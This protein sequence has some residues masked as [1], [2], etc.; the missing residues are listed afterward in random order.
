[1]HYFWMGEPWSL[2]FIVHVWSYLSWTEL[3]SALL[4]NCPVYWSWRLGIFSKVRGRHWSFSYCF[5]ARWIRGRFGTSSQRLLRGHSKFIVLLPQSVRNTIVLAHTRWTPTKHRSKIQSA[6]M[7]HVW[8]M[9][10][11]ICMMREL[12]RL[13]CVPA[14]N[15]SV[16]GKCL[17]KNIS[18]SRPRCFIHAKMSGQ[19]LCNA[20]SLRVQSCVRRWMRLGL[21]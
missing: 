6:R 1:M 17:S 2:I 9:L 16:P 12:F 21:S 5:F 10:Y 3:E 20:S 8:C 14:T 7:Q 13:E 4:Q 19:D 18:Y 11:S 15:V